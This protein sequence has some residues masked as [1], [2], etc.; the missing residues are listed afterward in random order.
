MPTMDVKGILIA[1][2]SLIIPFVNSYAI[3][4]VD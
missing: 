4:S 2:V 1:V 3:S